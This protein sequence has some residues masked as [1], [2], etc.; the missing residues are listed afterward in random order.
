VRWRLGRR[1]LALATPSAIPP[2]PRSCTSGL[3]EYTFWDDEA[4][5]ASY[6]RALELLP[7]AA[8]P[9]ARG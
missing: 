1:A 4:A 5:L 2:A 8:W 3:G 7:E 9:S 6:A